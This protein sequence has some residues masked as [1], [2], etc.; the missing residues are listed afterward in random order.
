[1]RRVLT[2]NQNINNPTVPSTTQNI[3][4]TRLQRTY[5]IP[6]RPNVVQRL[7]YVQQN[8]TIKS[9]NEIDM[10][11]DFIR[12]NTGQ[13]SS[14]SARLPE[15]MSLENLLNLFSNI[16]ESIK[17][18]ICFI[19]KKNIYLLNCHHEICKECYTNIYNKYYE[20]YKSDNPKCPFCKDEIIGIKNIPSS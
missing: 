1:M 16:N 15:G 11:D 20:G 14:S 8:E 17:C 19:N 13:S 4:L 9:R 7:E 12:A 10:I 2:F 3:P 6:Y 18:K 5:T